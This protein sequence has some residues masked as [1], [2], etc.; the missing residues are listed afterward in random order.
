M[1]IKKRKSIISFLLCLNV[2]IP[3][4]AFYMPRASAS[5]LGD[6]QDIT[7][8]GFDSDHPSIGFDSTSGLMYY[9]YSQHVAEGNVNEICFGNNSAGADTMENY[10]YLSEGESNTDPMNT[11]D[12]FNPILWVDE[13]DIV[14]IVWQ[15]KINGRSDYDIFYTNT[16]NHNVLGN[17]I[18]V[19]DT[20]STNETDPT[21][22]A[23]GGHVFIAYYDGTQIRIK[24]TLGDKIDSS[25]TAYAL[26]QSGDGIDPELYAWSNGTDWRLDFSYIDG[27]GNII[28]ENITKSEGN[29]NALDDDYITINHDGSNITDHSLASNKNMAAF[30]YRES[31]N[32]IYVANSTNPSNP[33]RITND[34]NAKGHPDILINENDIITIFYVLNITGGNSYI[35]S[36]NNF[37]S[38]F[39]NI[40]YTISDEEMPQNVN[41]MYI[42]SFDAQ[43]CPGEG[44]VILYDAATKINPNPLGHKILYL[45]SYGNIYNNGSGTYNYYTWQDDLGG[46]M[47]D[48]GWLL[49][50]IQISYNV[51]SGQDR[52]MI[53]KIKDLITNVTWSTPITLN[54]SGGEDD[55]IYFFNLT[56]HYFIAQNIFEVSIL[57]ASGKDLIRIEMNPL[58]FS[59]GSLNVTAYSNY[60]TNG[61][62]FPYTVEVYSDGFEFTAFFFDKDIYWPNSYW[63]RDSENADDTSSGTFNN[64]NYVDLYKFKMTPGEQYNFSLTAKGTD[65]KYCRIM[66]FNSSVQITDPSKAI[67]VYNT[68]ANNGTYFQ[69][70]SSTEDI[71]YVVIEKFSKLASFSYD[72]VHKVCPM[73]ADLLTPT[74][75][76]IGESTVFFSWDLN[77]EEDSFTRN[78]YTDS[79]ID[80]YN[81]TLVDAQYHIKYSTTTND[82]NLSLTIIK[83]SN[84]KLDLPDGIYYWYIKI[85]AKNHQ[86]S[87]IIYR[88][89]NLDTTAPEAPIMYSPNTYSDTGT[90][91][92]NWSTASD[93]IF[94]VHHYELYRGSSSDFECNEETLI[95]I[96]DTLKKTSY[97]EYDMKSEIY[98]YKVIAVDNVG[99][100]SEPSNVGRYIV[101][102]GG[103][104][105]PKG[106]VFKVLPGQYLEY[107]LVDVIDGTTKD[108]DELYATF[109]GQ[110]LQMYTLLYFWISE[111]SSDQ[112]IPVRGNWYKKWMNTTSIQLNEEFKLIGKDKD[113][114]PLVTT[115]DTD[116]QTKVFQLFINRTFDNATGFQHDLKK[117][118]YFNTFSAIEVYVHSFYKS[119]DYSQSYSDRDYLYDTVTFVVDA[120]T[121]VVIELVLY[122]DY[123]E[124]GYS[125]KL[126]DTNV[127]LAKIDWWIFPLTVI[128][129]L[130]VIA[131]IIN[132]IVK[133]LERRV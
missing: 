121:G 43:Y 62:D 40:E 102:I 56:N 91:T 118:W 131:A 20:P 107:Q 66:V 88:Q 28:Y 42:S 7:A 11:T 17:I 86:S 50:G 72:F 41:E 21:V 120:N 99:L 45:S 106:Q 119:I 127:P 89:F 105:D 1:M 31:N 64:Q 129:V 36:S 98:Y 39:N 76:Y 22:V 94:S 14:H 115:S 5:F 3:L 87:K 47:K 79:D 38:Y 13:N 101:S 133:R 53:I 104:V 63:E 73:K 32:D 124:K 12:N 82:K 108:P 84:P 61:T 67:L 6:S 71:Y 128:F 58:E 70:Y 35:C 125:L 4:I 78:Y 24:T 97:R 57:N 103:Y 23:V 93:G 34:A 85:V 15:G 54:G 68:T 113:L 27:S 80:Y 122:D 109:K 65:S 55:K 29:I 74:S 112:I 26:T 52:N 33:K 126:I 51:S 117:T 59:N 90:Y 30:C 114:F 10:I 8:P 60:N 77:S 100:K 132:L 111:V 48:A 44:I 9:V 110:T 18:N 130:G 75:L 37:V 83:G 96:G 69:L 25:G 46:L 81:F 95:S 92:V 116:Y 49:E 16:S 19:T 2:I 123:N